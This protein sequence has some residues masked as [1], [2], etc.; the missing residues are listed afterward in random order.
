MK[1]L[2]LS[3]C[4][5]LTV[6][7]GLAETIA[8]PKADA[9]GRLTVEQAL[10]TRRSVRSY[11][12]K[13]ITVKDLGQLLWAAQGVTT[14][15]GRRT[16]PSAGAL[17]PLEVTAIAVRVDGLAP[18]IYRYRPGAHD[19]Q[20]LATG[21]FSKEIAA[22]AMH[23][24][25]VSEA[26]AMVVISAVEERTAKKY[27]SRAPRYVAFETGAASENLALQAVALGLGSLC[28]GAFD[29]G[30]LTTAAH[31][32]AGERPIILMPVGFAR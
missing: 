24:A 31:L 12:P 29:D 15:D 6:A 11:S 9:T 17:Y 32:P 27:G 8:L 3:C 23:Q 13:P 25:A 5:I 7:C 19:L 1:V 26:P 16:A 21:D 28:V 14:A 20:P 22:A 4:A 30:Q 2:V 18:G 10:R